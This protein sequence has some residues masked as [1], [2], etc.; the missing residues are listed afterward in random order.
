MHWKDFLVVIFVIFLIFM[1]FVIFY[2]GE[3]LQLFSRPKSGLGT[4]DRYV[5]LTVYYILRIMK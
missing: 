2:D 1:I 3:E 4:P 5:H